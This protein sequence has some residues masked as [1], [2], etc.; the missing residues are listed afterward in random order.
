MPI[1]R[2]ISKNSMNCNQLIMYRTYDTEM[3]DIFMKTLHML[4]I[5]K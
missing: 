3:V 4:K 2:T 1:N 5:K